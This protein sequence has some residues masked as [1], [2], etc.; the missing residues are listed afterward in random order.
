MSR[1]FGLLASGT[2]TPRCPY[3][4]RGVFC[5][6]DTCGANLA[7]LDHLLV[8]IQH[9]GIPFRECVVRRSEG[10]VGTGGRRHL[11]KVGSKIGRCACDEQTI[12]AWL[13]RRIQG[14]RILSL[15]PGGEA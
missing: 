10:R 6:R 11:G 3:G 15:G 7:L 8:A 2:R 5:G 12:E 13:V 9:S 1:D 4:W 14:G